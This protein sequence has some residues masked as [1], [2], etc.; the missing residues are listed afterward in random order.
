MSL[1]NVTMVMVL[2]VA[3]AE[4]ETLVATRNCRLMFQLATD[5]ARIRRYRHF[6]E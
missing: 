3:E 6:L 1:R 4:R 5:E 2:V